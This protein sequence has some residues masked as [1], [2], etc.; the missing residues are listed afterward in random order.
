L[1]AAAMLRLEATGY[2]IVLHVHDEIISEVPEGSG[3]EKKFVEIMTALPDWAPGLP[4]AAK[5]WS[6]TRYAKDEKSKSKNTAP[7]DARAR[8]NRG[9]GTEAL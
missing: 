5:P 3:D 6:G 2:P 7:G 4:V 1:L 8:K 9:F